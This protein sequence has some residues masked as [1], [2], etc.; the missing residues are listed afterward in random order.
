LETFIDFFAFYLVL[1]CVLTP[2]MMLTMILKLTVYE[3]TVR[4]DLH[5][6]C[7]RIVCHVTELSDVVNAV[8]YLLS[9]SAAMINGVTLPIEGGY[10]VT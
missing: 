1:Q 10:L 9:D 4:Y 3:V 5:V 2:F 6:K 7:L 8:L